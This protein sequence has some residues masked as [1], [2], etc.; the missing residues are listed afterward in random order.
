MVIP[1]DPHKH[2]HPSPDMDNLRDCTEDHGTFSPSGPTIV[3]QAAQAYAQYKQLLSDMTW[4]QFAE[5]DA[6]TRAE[7]RRTYDTC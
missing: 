5:F 3:E 7:Y 2:Q 1:H 4:E 6:L